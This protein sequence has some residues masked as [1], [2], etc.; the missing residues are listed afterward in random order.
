MIKIEFSLVAFPSK[1]LIARHEPHIK[2]SF[3]LEE[4]NKNYIAPPVPL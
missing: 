2:V 4:N 3:A 1:K